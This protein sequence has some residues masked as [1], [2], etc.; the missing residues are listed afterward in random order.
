MIEVNNKVYR[1]LQQQ[2]AKNME[3]IEQLEKAYGYKGPFA[4]T[5][6]IKE[7]IDQALYL[8]GTTYPYKVYQYKEL[9]NTYLFLGTFAAAGERGPA[10]PQGPQGP[11]GI[12]GEQGPKGE[13]G[14]QGET[15][16]QGERGPR[17][18]QGPQ[19]I[20][21]PEGPQGEPGTK[22]AN[23][24]KTSSVGRVDTYTITMTDG[25]TYNFTVT[26]GKDGSATIEAGYGI[27]INGD[28]ISVDQTVVALKN[29]LNSYLKDN[30]LNYSGTFRGK[31]IYVKTEG[32]YTT[33][34]YGDGSIGRTL[35]HG[36]PGYAYTLP[37]KS[38]TF[39]MTDDIITSYNDLTDKPSIPTKTSDL[40]NDSGFITSAALTS[41]VTTTQL[42]D[43]LDDYALKTDI[44]E[45]VSDL[46]NDAGYTTQTWVEN[47]GYSK[48]SGNY[49]DLTN[50]PDL[51]VY[52]L[53]SEA[54]S[55]D[56]D[57]L[58]NKP[59]IPTATS[60]LTNDSGFIT[61]VTW[62]D[63]TGK[64]TFATVA[65]SGSYND[66]S[67]KPTIPSNGT[68]PFLGIAQPS[69]G[70]VVFSADGTNYF[71]NVSVNDNLKVNLKAL[72]P[73][74]GTGLT[75]SYN[76]STNALDVAVDT[77]TVALKSELPAAVSGT[78]DGTNWTSLTIGNDTYGVGG[79]GS[80]YTF[81]NG[82]TENSGTVTSDLYPYIRPEGSDS[83][84][85]RLG[86]P[87]AVPMR[88]VSMKVPRLNTLQ[89]YPGNDIY[90]LFISVTDAATESRGIYP[91]LDGGL[92]LGFS[93]CR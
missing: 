27:N 53:K 81:T 14:I 55:G 5:D 2:V 11:A 47:Q 31:A 46:T 15:G 4:S 72:N 20:Q 57:D 6:D 24:V 76:S 61:G 51:S 80:S 40:T 50:K 85:L 22:I 18:V 39:A 17:G 56:Y 43:K 66:L 87:N 69:L 71:A 26:N 8:I 1:N 28:E 62:N 64:P 23:I 78:N 73:N 33:T 75:S 52:E 30:D 88:I 21:G 70:T 44:P 83:T 13:Q 92:N 65:T 34:T 67:D 35:P 38:G 60:Q 16:P 25:T 91:A 89:I 59:T 84:A 79:G 48:F 36:Q 42:D 77:T 10:G 82:L 68:T 19:G 9:T 49:N 41:Y 7:P 32:N 54:F 74:F 37:D 58:T 63:V 90:G 12:P 29:E 86:N 3:D 93:A 45:N